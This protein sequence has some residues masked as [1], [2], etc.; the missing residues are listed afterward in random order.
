[1]TEPRSPR[2]A[3][4]GAVRAWSVAAL[5]LGMSMSAAVEFSFLL[6]FVT[7]TAATGYEMLKSGKLMIDTFGIA[8]T[9][10][11]CPAASVA[12]ANYAE[13]FAVAQKPGWPGYLGAPQLA[14]AA[15]ASGD[16]ASARM[17]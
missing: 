9:A 5:L 14:T 15:F 7:L 16:S 1:M 17:A 6:G 8:T 13:A 2:P 12:G 4:E 11:H 10:S 3:A